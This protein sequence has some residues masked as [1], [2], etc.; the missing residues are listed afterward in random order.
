MAL[1]KQQK[2]LLDSDDND[3]KAREFGARKGEFV[4]RCIRL[5]EGKKFMVLKEGDYLV[6]VIQYFTTNNPDVDPGKPYFVRSYWRHNGLGA[7]NRDSYP[8]NLKNFGKKCYCCDYLNSRRADDLSKEQKKKISAKVRYLWNIIDLNDRKSGVVVLDNAPYKGLGDAVKEMLENNRGR[9]DGFAKVRGGVSLRFR[10]KEEA[11]GEGKMKAILR[12]DPE[13]RRKD[14]DADIVE[15]AV[16]LDECI[17]EADYEQ[18][19]RAMGGDDESDVNRDDHDDLSRPV[20]DSHLPSRSSANGKARHDEDEDE[21]DGDDRPQ[22]SKRLD[23]DE[24]DDDGIQV[25]AQV[26]YN[27]QTCTV[28]KII[29]GKLRM[30]DEEG[31]LIS[32]DVLPTAVEVIG[33]EEDSPPKKAKGRPDPDD[34]SPAPKKRGR[35]KKVQASDDDED[36]PDDDDDDGEEDA[37]IP[38][39]KTRK[40]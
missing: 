24:D 15:E 28:V 3:A 8:C 22:K 16:N 2:A 33:E 34:D 6:D 36:D 13:P 5:P 32:K 39:K 20:N 4:N 35:P 37:D 17:L 25:G 23:P 1:T 30:I 29:N 9:Y 26:R 18:V 10:V 21:D 27:G 40:K 14:Y 38:R 19:K 11:M 12:V 31:D 7:D